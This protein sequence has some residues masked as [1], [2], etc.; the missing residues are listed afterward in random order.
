LL[1]R[2][3]TMRL[4]ELKKQHPFRWWAM[5]MQERPKPGRGGLLRGE[6]AV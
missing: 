4:I 3:A 6:K 5:L 1:I 2:L